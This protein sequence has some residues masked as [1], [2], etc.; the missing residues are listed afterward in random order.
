MSYLTGNFEA[1]KDEEYIENW[2]T[3]VLFIVVILL[4]ILFELLVTAAEEYLCRRRLY[5]LQEMLNCAFKELTI[6][7]FISLFLYTTVRL[8]VMRKLN[9]KYLGVSKTEEA[10]IEAAESQ[11]EE[12]YP[13]THLTETFETIH[14]LIFMI[15]VTFIIQI[16]ALAIFGYRTM[17]KLEILDAKTE[18]DLQRDIVSAS[19]FGRLREGNIR[20]ALEH[21]G[22]RQRFVSATNPLM[23]KPRWPEPGFPPFSFAAYLIRCFGESLANMIEL[24]PSILILTLLIVILLRPALS[25]AGREVVIFMIILAFGLLSLTF[26]AYSFLKYADTKIRPD[27]NALVALFSSYDVNAEDASTAFRCPIDDR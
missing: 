27:Y 23:P 21:W 25:L 8:G 5:K 4:S 6:L 2:V 15:M 10:A 7:G 18:E 1:E 17:R 12:P 22:I 14:V 26:L 11:G 9:D 20:E 13:P 16:A 3:V 19:S 24:P